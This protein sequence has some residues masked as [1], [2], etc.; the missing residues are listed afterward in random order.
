MKI[1]DRESLFELIHL[2][3]G[4][5]R[6]QVLFTAHGLN[7]F[8]KLSDGE[9][10]PEELALQ[11]GSSV[12][13]TERLL[14]ACVALGLLKKENGRYSNL[15]IADSFLVE[16]RPQYMGH[17]INLMSDWYQPWGRL[18]EAIRTGKPVED[19]FEHLGGRS[20]YTRDFILAMHDYANGP[21]RDMVRHVDLTDRKRL[22]DMGGGPGTY[23]ILLAQNYPQL[24]AV[25]FD[26]PPVIEIAREVI[27]GYDGIR[28]RVTT[29]A[30]D[31]LVDDW[32]KGYDVILLSNML[33]QEDPETCKMI[34]RKAYD[35][36]ED[37]G[38]LVVQGSFLN[39]DKNGPVWPTLQSLQILLVYQGGRTY[40]VD[41]M[42]VLINEVGFSNPEHKKIS[43]HGAESIIVATK[44]V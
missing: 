11:C 16:E 15:R 41:E 23:S 30:G 13:Y 37:G 2:A 12:E 39:R 27:S 19:P 34:I 8:D 31:Y 17:W 14:S 29:Q 4:Y 22:L 7:V 43:F 3:L 28:N 10:A 33:H 25:V 44:E 38:L 32:G 24:N 26:L 36:L 18:P 6:A 5:W 35:A 21:G 40:S 1:R 9:I 42:V 20:D